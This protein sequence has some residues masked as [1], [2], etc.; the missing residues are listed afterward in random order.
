M[1]G[2]EQAEIAETA[3]CVYACGSAMCI[4]SHVMVCVCAVLIKLITNK[5]NALL[6]WF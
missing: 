5:T 3:E 6:D 4:Y 2:G 1:S